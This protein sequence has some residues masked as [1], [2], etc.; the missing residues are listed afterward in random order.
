MCSKETLSFFIFFR[1]QPYD[2][3]TLLME[4]LATRHAKEF[5]FPV[6]SSPRHAKKTYVTS[7]FPRAI[8][9]LFLLAKLKE[10][11]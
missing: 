8:L 2:G 3:A 7:E 6:F 9:D 1:R 5:G 4:P 10:L 11:H